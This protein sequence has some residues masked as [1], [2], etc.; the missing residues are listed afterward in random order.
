MK[1]KIKAPAKINLT[2]EVLNK[3]NDGYH[4]IK[5]LMQTISLYDEVTVEVEENICGIKIICNDPNV[6]T[7]ESNIVY[8]AVV[9]FCEFTNTKLPDLTIDIDKNIPVEAG[10]AGGSADAAAVIVALNKL[11]DKGLDADALCDIGEEVGA[12][13]PFCI[14]GGSMI[15]EGVGNILTPLPHMPECYIAVVK[16]HSS[17]STKYAYEL[18]DEGKPSFRDDYTDKVAEAICDND[19]DAIANNLYNQFETVTDLPEVDKI[20]SIIKNYRA[21]GS[22]MSGSGSAVFGLFDN[23]GDADD[24]LDELNN[25]FDKTYLCKPVNYGCYNEEEQ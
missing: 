20:K 21:K 2:L 23:K 9:K 13:V 25:S 16:P 19:L 11:F 14:L 18:V 1:V 15:A 6:P 12:D 22:L 8:K 3:R 17:I 5:S 10:L 24:A 7:D 4:V